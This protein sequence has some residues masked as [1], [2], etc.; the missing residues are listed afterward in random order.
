MNEEIFFAT[1]AVCSYD[2]ELQAVSY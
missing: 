1:T 2:T